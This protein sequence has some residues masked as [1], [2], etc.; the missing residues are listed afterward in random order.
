MQNLI[1]SK[2]AEELGT[3]EREVRKKLVERSFLLDLQY[4]ETVLKRIRI[5]KAKKYVREKY[6]AFVKKLNLQQEKKEARAA[7]ED[8]EPI[9]EGDWSPVYYDATEELEKLAINGEEYQ[10][11]LAKTWEEKLR[12]Q[13]DALRHAGEKKD[14]AMADG[15]DMQATM[16]FSLEGGDYDKVAEAMY[17]QEK[18]RPMAEDEEPFNDPATIDMNEDILGD[19]KDQKFMLKKPL[20]FN[21]VKVGYE[22]NK[23]HQ[24][25]SDPDN[26]PPKSVQGY[27]FNIFYPHLIDRTRT[28]QFYLRPSD[29]TGTLLIKFHAGPPYED[30]AFRILNKEWD[31]SEKRGFK[32]VFDR[33]ILH[34]HFNFKKLRYKR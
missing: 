7:E 33:G 34:L 1:E 18:E 6:D 13:I 21:R 22:W 12:T 16:R 4:W 30:I 10:E 27:K 17:K 14:R 5:A 26:P 32:C 20:S 2:A 23:Y 8:K 15:E 19:P 25:H 9:Q 31:L 3:I 29:V 24:T 11:N 28:P